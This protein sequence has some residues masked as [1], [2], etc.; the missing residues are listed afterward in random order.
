MSFA[1]AATVD[2]VWSG[3]KLGVTVEGVPVLL[4]NVDGVV[5]AYEDR[6][7]HQAVPLSDGRLEGCVLTCRAHEWT[8]DARTGQGIN[9]STVALRVLPVRVHAGEIQVDARGGGD[10]QR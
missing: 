2:D 8:F 9:P 4:V 3:E 5:H 6:C 7:A 1:F 10:G